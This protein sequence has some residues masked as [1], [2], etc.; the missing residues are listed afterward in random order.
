MTEI[1]SQSFIHPKQVTLHGLLK[2][3]CRK[4]YGS[5]IL[6]VPRMRKLMGH[7]ISKIEQFEF[8]GECLFS[9]TIFTRLVMFETLATTVI[10]KCQKKFVTSIM[11]C[12]EQRRGFSYQSVKTIRRFWFDFE[13]R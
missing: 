13:C 12:T 9:N 4:S 2:I 6:P 1:L 3:W 11:M 7:Q 10:A 5:S 8:I